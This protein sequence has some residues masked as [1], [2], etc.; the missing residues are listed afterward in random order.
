MKMNKK[1]NIWALVFVLI[2]LIMFIIIYLVITP[3]IDTLVTQFTSNANVNLSPTAISFLN[4]F[5]ILWDK[6]IPG[7][8]IFGLLLYGIISALR[9]EPY[10]QSPPQQ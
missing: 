9:K 6:V 8:L 7:F 1:G 2:A 3:A 4:F 10:A 5:Q